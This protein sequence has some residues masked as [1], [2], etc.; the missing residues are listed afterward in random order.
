MLRDHHDWFDFNNSHFRLGATGNR[1]FLHDKSDAVE[2]DC[3][4]EVSSLS[5][6]DFD[7]DEGELGGTLY[8]QEPSD[9]SQAREAKKNAVSRK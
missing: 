3:A 4:V 7:L 6:V 9:T 1:R 8:W 2:S 5:L